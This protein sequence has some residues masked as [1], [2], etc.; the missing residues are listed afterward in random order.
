MVGDMFNDSLKAK[1]NAIAAEVSGYPHDHLAEQRRE[2]APVSYRSDGVPESSS[3]W[4]EALGTSSTVGSQNQMRYAAF[5]EK[6]VLSS[7]DHGE[8]EIYD[9]GDHRISGTADCAPSACIN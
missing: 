8:T 3:W 4:P 9:T 1:L 5:P 2:N 7:H 6:R